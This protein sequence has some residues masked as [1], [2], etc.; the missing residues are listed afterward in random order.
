MIVGKKMQNPYGSMESER[1]NG[2]AVSSFVSWGSKITTVV[3][4]LGSVTDWVRAKT[5]RDGIY[6][7]FV[8]A[9]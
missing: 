9:T 3:A 8:K 4:L 5:R 7:A 6:E 1:V 2:K